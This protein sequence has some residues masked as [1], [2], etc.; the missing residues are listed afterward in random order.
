MIT[1]MLVSSFVVVNG[2]K[3]SCYLV[4]W[5]KMAEKVTKYA[6]IMVFVTLIKIESLILTVNDFKWLLLYFASFL[7]ISNA[8]KRPDLP[9]IWPN[10]AE[11]LAKYA[12]IRIF[13]TLIKNDLIVW[14]GNQ[15]KCLLLCASSSIL[16]LNDLKETWL[17]WNVAK[18][19][20]KT[21]KIWKNQRFWHF[22]QN[23]VISFGWK[24]L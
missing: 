19:G 10:M 24:I 21:C 2:F 3:R 4:I 17:S 23:W 16:V 11:R 22:D 8:E 6:K 18:N 15:F 20:Q 13:D 1:I 14:V 9:Y 5:S 7:L 12:K